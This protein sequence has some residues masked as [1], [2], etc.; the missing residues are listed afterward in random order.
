MIGQLP[1]SQTFLNGEESEKRKKKKEGN[2][3]LPHMY[4]LTQMTKE[5]GLR[6]KAPK[7]KK[8]KGGKA[9]KKNKR[10]GVSHISS[11][12]HE[13]GEN[14][15]EEEEKKYPPKSSHSQ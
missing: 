11:L 2:S 8:K 4:F 13:I 15:R 12:Q 5:G 6:G 7:K 9:P 14:N 3:S 1:S 10:K